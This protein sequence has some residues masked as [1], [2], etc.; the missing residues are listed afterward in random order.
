MSILDDENEEIV[1]NALDCLSSLTSICPGEKKAK[2]LNLL[3]KTVKFLY[4]EVCYIPIYSHNLI[5]HI[6]LSYFKFGL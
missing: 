2:E 6:G 5:N 3:K 4:D 1:S